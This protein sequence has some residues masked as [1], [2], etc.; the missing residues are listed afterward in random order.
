MLNVPSTSFPAPS[1]QQ[2][3]A[4]LGR[5]KVPLK[6]GRSLMDWIRLT[7]SGKDLTGLRGRLIEVTEEEL[8]RHNK[9][10]DC[11]MCIRGLVYNVSQYMEYHPGGEKELMR[12]A[13]ADGTELFDQTHRWVN[14]ESMLKE[15]LI[16]RMAVKPISISKGTLTQVKVPQATDTEF[17]PRY[18]WFQTDSAVTVVVYTKQEN[19]GLDLVIVD[20]QENVL[21]GEVILGDFS[22]LLLIELNHE[23]QKKIDVCVS[24]K[25]G[26]IELVLQK[27]ETKVWKTLGQY[28]E[29]HDS[30]IKSFQRG[31]FYRKCRLASKIAVNYNTRLFCFELPKGCN[32]PV[33]VGHHVYIKLPIAGVEVVK[34]YTPVSHSLMLDPKNK[35]ICENQCIYLMVKIYPEG[36]FSPQLDQL[37]IG[38]Y[39][40]VSNPQGNFK[41][42]QI[43]KVEDIFFLAAGTGLTPMVKLLR[44]VLSY[45]H[46][47]RKAKLLFFNKTEDDI[48]WRDQIV[49]LS[50]TNERFEIQFILSEPSAKW[51][52]CKGRISLPFLSET[53]TRSERESKVLICI[54]GPN[55]FVDQGIRFLQDLGFSSEEVFVFKE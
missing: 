11:W 12:A 37:S 18:D 28:L 43:E 50:L 3:V 2:R 30:F 1:S 24:A 5:S 35:S 7:K 48:L 42:S 27:R 47:L 14:Y 15:C 31:L 13:G 17:R 55:G 22:Y 21:R 6:P 32:F 8:S 38:D 54:C 19:M 44:H 20:Y 49:D 16:G 53:I 39:I 9:K 51:N 40:A 29:G 45:H 26:K 41:M 4:T 23:I 33:P 34:P 10:N 52:G 36:S 25:A 46:S